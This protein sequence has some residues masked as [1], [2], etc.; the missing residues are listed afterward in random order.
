MRYVNRTNCLRRWSHTLV[1]IARRRVMITRNNAPTISITTIDDLFIVGSLADLQRTHGCY[2]D[3]EPSYRKAWQGYTRLSGSDHPSTNFML[4]NLGIAC[5]NQEKSIE[6]ETHLEESV[7]AFEKSLGSDHPDT[8]RALTNLSVCIDRQGHYKAAEA[9]YGR[10][11]AGT[12]EEA[13]F[14]IF[15]QSKDHWVL[16]AYALDAGTPW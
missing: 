7:K 14:A 8:L 1:N 4:T 13:G 16:S 11:F 3:A 9:N 10:N 12:R 6:A 15:I 2:K 5:C